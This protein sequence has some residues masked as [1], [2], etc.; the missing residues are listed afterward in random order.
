MIIDLIISVLLSLFG[1]IFSFLP[2]VTLADIPYA[3]EGISSTLLW[4][5]TT[6]NSFMV[7]FPYAE[8]AWSIFLLIIVPFELLLLVAKFFLGHRVPAHTTN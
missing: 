7:T 5:V 1:F 4:M 6:W 3:G 2:V 8:T